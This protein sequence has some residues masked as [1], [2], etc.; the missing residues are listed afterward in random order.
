MTPQIKAWRKDKQDKA[1]KN[2]IAMELSGLE[3]SIS[4]I[5]KERQERNNENRI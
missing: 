4:K 2:K 5:L 3:L 1:N